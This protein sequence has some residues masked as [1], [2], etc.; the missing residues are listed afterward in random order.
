MNEN[1]QTHIEPDLL[2]DDELTDGD[3]L[4]FPGDDVQLAT[5]RQRVLAARELLVAALIARTG[6]ILETDNGQG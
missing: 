3:L 5:T 1:A 6:E 4:W 2:R